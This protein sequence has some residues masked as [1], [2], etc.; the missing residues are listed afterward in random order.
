MV[1]VLVNGEWSCLVGLRARLSFA[2]SRVNC[3]I[4]LI[5]QRGAVGTL[6]IPVN[7]GRPDRSASVRS[8]PCPLHRVKSP[9]TPA[10]EPRLFSGSGGI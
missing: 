10:E 6:R 7:S 1:D 3:S 9:E 5:C 8:R 2:R 4:V